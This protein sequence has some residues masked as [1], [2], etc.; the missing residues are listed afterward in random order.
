MAVAVP[1]FSEGLDRDA[2]AAISTAFGGAEV[3]DRHTDEVHNRTVLTL[4]APDDAIVAELA[5]GARECVERIDMN[6]HNGAHPCV[7][8]LDVCPLVWLTESDHATTKDLALATAA[9]IAEL[10]VPVFLYGELASAEE[11]RE[12]VYFRRGGLELLSGRMRLG[13]LAPDLGP[14]RPHPTAGATL[15]TARP[16]LAAFNLELDTD[17]VDVARAIAP[18]AARVRGRSGRRA[19]G[20]DRSRRPGPGLDQHPRPR[21][22]PARRRDRARPRARGPPRRP[23]GR[24]AR[25]SVSYPRRRSPG[26]PRTCRC[27]T[28]DADEQVL[29]RRLERLDR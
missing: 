13:E 20:R 17:E 12:R 5:A 15:V 29:E 9:E 11:R 23:A 19:G 28:F 21:R 16:P 7:G 6:E 3:L 14:S 10:G 18:E 27:G 26:C 4:S 22:G 25:S 1:N 2:V 8:A 24:A